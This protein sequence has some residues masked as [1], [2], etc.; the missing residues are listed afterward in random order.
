L[1]DTHDVC[2]LLQQVRTN[3]TS[4]SYAS[5]EMAMQPHDWLNIGPNWELNNQ[6]GS[7]LPQWNDYDCSPPLSHMNSPIDHPPVSEFSDSPPPYPTSFNTSTSLQVPFDFKTNTVT[8]PQCMAMPPQQCVT[9]QFSLQQSLAIEQ[10]KFSSI[11][12]TPTSSSD[13]DS[14][15]SPLPP[16]E[17]QLAA[18]FSEELRHVETKEEVLKLI[19]KDVRVPQS[20]LVA[21]SC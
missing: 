12:D 17:K 15:A 7:N 19:P 3:V 11:S 18:E 13:E 10:F 4:S 2:D 14:S 9:S 16:A 5:G 20:K 21:L 1:T 8:S 6:Q